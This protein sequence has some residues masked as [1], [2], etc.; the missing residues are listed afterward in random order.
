MAGSGAAAGGGGGREAVEGGDG[1]ECYGG[2]RCG[3]GSGRLSRGVPRVCAHGR[4]QEIQGEGSFGAKAGR[5]GVRRQ[6]GWEC[7][8]P[9]A[10]SVPLQ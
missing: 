4:V 1:W 3:G 8:Y 10:R 5:G 7:L 2:G 6:V 9:R